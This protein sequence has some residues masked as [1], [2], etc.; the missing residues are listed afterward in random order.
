LIV[1][2]PAGFSLARNWPI[3]NYIQFAQLWMKAFPASQFVLLLL[4]NHQAKAHQIK[5]ALGNA[6]V[7]LTGKADQVMAFSILSKCAMVLSEDSGLMHM[8]WVQKVPTIALFSSS[9]ADWSAPQG[10]WSVCLN[11]SDMECGPC[12]LEVCK[13][14]DN[15]C[16]TRYSPQFVLEKALTVVR[17]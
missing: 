10:E 11:S 2:N 3:E 17:K 13:F 8:A 15:R 4:P 9:R 7:D 1:L 6:C 14:G 5:V 12:Q 16:L